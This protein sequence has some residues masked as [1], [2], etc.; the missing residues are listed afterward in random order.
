M[1]YLVSQLLSLFSPLFDPSL[2]LLNLDIDKPPSHIKSLRDLPTPSSSNPSVKELSPDLLI[3][4]LKGV[5]KGSVEKLGVLQYLVLLIIGFFP[6]REDG[7]DLDPPFS[8]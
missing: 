8:H 2:L 3:V 6:T 4:R 1:G 5:S 7:H